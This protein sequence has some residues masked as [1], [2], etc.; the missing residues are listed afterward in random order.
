MPL[1]SSL[2]PIGAA[3]LLGIAFVLPMGVILGTLCAL[4]LIGSVIAAVHHAEVVAHRTGEPLGTLVLALA[5]TVIEVAL[6][7][8]M[9]L[10][11]GPD[12]NTLPRDT[13]F[14]A[15][16]VICNGLLG[17][18][19]LIGSLR[20]REQ[21]FHVVG[22]NA[23]LA[24]L[25]A[26]TTLSLV[27]PV[28]TTSSSG[29]TYTNGQLVFASIAS[30][31][32]WG[33]FVFVQ[34]IRHRDYFLPVDNVADENIHAPPPSGRLAL[35]SFLLLFVALVNVVGLAKVMSPVIEAGVIEVGAPKGV[36]GIAIAILV[37]L[38]ETWA[39]F[40]AARANRL[41]TS[42]NLALGSALASIGLTIPAVAFTSMLI[43]MP[44]VLGL[45]PKD[46]TLLLL[47]FLVASI[48]LVAGRTNVMLAAVHLVIF[49]A[50]LLLAFV[51]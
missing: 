13:I 48:T 44:L 6:I 15:I 49:G 40:R 8:T 23:A 1:W 34:T 38:P 27:L 9:M 42:M 5:I 19:L 25:V 17:V 35:L 47:T 11:G 39:A 50:F 28:F 51:P 24:T 4:A 45:D 36:I 7:V 20:H 37:L 46:L 33:V 12:K 18:C 2:I 22:A 26:L 3:A 32:L 43:G 10:S 14:S 30:L 41:Q 21:T 29:P 31:V 16:M